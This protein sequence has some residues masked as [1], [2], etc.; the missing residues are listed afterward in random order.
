MSLRNLQS[1]CIYHRSRSR[2]HCS[3]LDNLF[4]WSK[5]WTSLFLDKSKT[6]LLCLRFL[7]WC[8]LSL[9]FCL[10]CRIWIFLKKIANKV[11]ECSYHLVSLPPKSTA[12]KKIYSEKFECI[13]SFIQTVHSLRFSV[14]PGYRLGTLQIL[15]SSSSSSCYLVWHY[16][17]GFWT[18]SHLN[19]G[20]TLD[21]LA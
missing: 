12:D 17:T 6:H 11:V 14:G 1:K 18:N 3:F 9:F 19:I 5:W 8:C 21:S 2:F 7:L 15:E 4:C 10:K 13:L 16:C 20:T